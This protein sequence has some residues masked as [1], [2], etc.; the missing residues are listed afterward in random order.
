MNV[1]NQLA[2]I[3]A[4]RLVASVD[5][6]ATLDQRV[7]LSTKPDIR[8]ACSCPASPG[9]QLRETGF[10]RNPLIFQ[11]RRRQTSSFEFPSNC[12]IR[13]LAAV[14]LGNLLTGGSRLYGWIN[15][16]LVPAPIHPR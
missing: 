7:K 4:G 9:P 2:S 11:Y 12:G 1:L 16:G 5:D 8:F 3:H 6:L 15:P 13:R 14:N 10:M